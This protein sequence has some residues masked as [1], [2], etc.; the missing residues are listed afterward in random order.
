MDIQLIERLSNKTNLSIFVVAELLQR[1]W[2][3]VENS[4]EISRWEHPMWHLEDGKV[5]DLD[6]PIRME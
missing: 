3:Y 5:P 4:G 1:G 6:R 2:R